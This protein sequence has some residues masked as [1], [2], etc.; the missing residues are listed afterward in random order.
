M[1]WI[2]RV[3][4][5]IPRK[6][7]KQVIY[8]GF[9]SQAW[10]GRE[11]RQGILPTAATEEEPASMKDRSSCSRWRRQL[12]AVLLKKVWDINALKCP[13]CGGQMKVI[14][15]IEQPSVIRRI[16]KHLDLWEDPRPPPEPL[17]LVCEPDADY[18]PWLDDVPGIEFLD[19]RVL[20]I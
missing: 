11:R 2:T 17:E 7:A 3:T 8:Y 4:S 15:V 13:K 18:I 9:Y 16:L 14:S 6:G 20:A 19:N 1:E 5:H 12:W 10:R